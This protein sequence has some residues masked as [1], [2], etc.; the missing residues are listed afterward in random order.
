MRLGLKNIGYQN[1]LSQLVDNTLLHL[2]ID[3]AESGRFVPPHKRNDILIQHLKPKIKDDRYRYVKKE[4]KQFISIGRK[5]KLDL[6][7]SLLEL[8]DI[9]I[10][11]TAEV[12]DAQR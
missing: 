1:Q 7:Q 11:P 10:D 5:P 4:I 12:S 8:K 3:C 6:E 2:Y 9:K